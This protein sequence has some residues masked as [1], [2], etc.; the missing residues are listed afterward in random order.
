MIPEQVWP[1]LGC[2]PGHLWS[3]LV[4][5]R[6]SPSACLGGHAPGRDR[7]L[8]T[9]AGLYTPMT[10]LV[11]RDVSATLLGGHVTCFDGT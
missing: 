7:I 4:S 3:A 2:C 6:C 1:Q 8:S 9:A 11:S 10:L 5:G